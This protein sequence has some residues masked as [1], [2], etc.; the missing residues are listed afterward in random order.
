MFELVVLLCAVLGAGILYFL[1]QCA[2]HLVYL[3]ADVHVIRL[4]LA[5][6]HETRDHPTSTP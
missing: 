6:Q 5:P 2:I 1:Y 4:L 3:R